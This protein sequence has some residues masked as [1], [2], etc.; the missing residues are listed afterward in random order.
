MQ[1]RALTPIVFAVAVQ[2][3]GCGGVSL[4]P[5]G[6]P[7]SKEI[8]RKPADATEYRCVGGKGFYVRNLEGNAVWLIAP[9]REIRL[10][11]PAGAPGTTY[12]AGKVRLEIAGEDA[13]LADPPAQFV[14]CRRADTK[15]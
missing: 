10:E 8:S 7:G 1:N 11:K 3:A 12:T 15:S 2:L 13:T 5:F 9:D 14:G 6:G 4:W